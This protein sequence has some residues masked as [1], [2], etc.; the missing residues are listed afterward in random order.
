MN[1]L[2]VIRDLDS[3]DRE[4]TIY[5][6]EPWSPDSMA[7]VVK[8]PEEGDPEEPKKIGLKYFLEV[9]TALEGLEAW[10]RNVN[11]NPTLAE[12]CDRVIYYATYDA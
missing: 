5:A 2:D 1:L 7:M 4:D 10:Q 8:E 3:F 9:Y 12:K 11:P 6:K